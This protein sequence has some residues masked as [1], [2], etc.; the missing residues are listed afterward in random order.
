MVFKATLGAEP[1][2]ADLMVLDIM[3]PTIEVVAEYIWDH[4]MGE[5][6]SPS[7]DE[8]EAQIIKLLDAEVP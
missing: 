3:G 8:V 4:M 6:D 2:N 1:R 7:C 5:P